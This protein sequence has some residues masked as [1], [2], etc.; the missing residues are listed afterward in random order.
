VV[1]LLVELVMPSTL[2]PL[3]ANKVDLSTVPGLGLNPISSNGE[4]VLERGEAVQ[5]HVHNQVRHRKGRI[6]TETHEEVFGR[7][8]LVGITRSRLRTRGKRKSGWR[9]EGGKDVASTTDC[10]QTSLLAVLQ[11]TEKRSYFEI[12]IVYRKLGAALMIPVK[13]C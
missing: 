6:E 7:E 1:L 4:S 12:T 13:L 8:K 5:G 9:K 11:R 10:K 3:P 2:S